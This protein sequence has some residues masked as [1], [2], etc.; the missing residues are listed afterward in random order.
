MVHSTED[1]SHYLLDNPR[2]HFVIEMVRHSKYC[3]NSKNID[4]QKI[5][6]INLKFEQYAMTNSINPNQKKTKNF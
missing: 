3:K 4:A 5:A 6:V 2:K 1:K